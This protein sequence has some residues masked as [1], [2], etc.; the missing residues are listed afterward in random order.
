MTVWVVHI[1][2]IG[3]LGCNS[4]CESRTF[5]ICY[6]R[7]FYLQL[8]LWTMYLWEIHT[9]NWFTFR[10]SVP[11]YPLWVLE[12][13]TEVLCIES[14]LDTVVLKCEAIVRSTDFL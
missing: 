6:R 11:M 2:P 4:P 5:K 3:D 8:V 9:S 14:M 10:L 12:S 1:F 13:G 7:C